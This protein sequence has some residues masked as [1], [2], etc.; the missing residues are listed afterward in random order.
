MEYEVI[1]GV[2]DLFFVLF[3]VGLVAVVGC[4]IN[5]FVVLIGGVCNAECVLYFA[6]SGM[7][8]GVFVYFKV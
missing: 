6:V 2:F 8:L 1:E 4:V 3:G 5:E 7:I